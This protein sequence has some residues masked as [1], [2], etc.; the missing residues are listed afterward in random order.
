MLAPGDGSDAVQVIDARDLAEWTI[1]MVESRTFGMFNAAGPG[2]ELS[3][4]EHA[5]RHPRRDHRRGAKLALGL[6]DVPRGAEGEAWGDMPVWV[7]RHRRDVGFGRRSVQRALAAGLTCR[8]LAQTALETLA[9]WKA[10]PAERQ[11]K[12]RAGIAPE[13]EKEVLAA[14]KAKK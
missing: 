5:A 6:G 4:G 8:P 13:R 12:L 9:W 2:Y 11:A 10:L 1:R 14:W 3:M 7:P